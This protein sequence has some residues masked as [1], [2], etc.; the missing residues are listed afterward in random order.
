MNARES[1]YALHDSHIASRSQAIYSQSTHDTQVAISS[2]SIN[3]IHDDWQ[4]SNEIHETIMRNKTTIVLT[5]S[6]D[7]VYKPMLKFTSSCDL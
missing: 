5:F 2:V 3:D 1:S 6:Y 7:L 4:G